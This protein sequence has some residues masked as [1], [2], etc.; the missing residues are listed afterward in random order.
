MHILDQGLKSKISNLTKKWF[1]KGWFAHIFLLAFTLKSILIALSKRYKFWFDRKSKFPRQKSE[2][3]QTI[4]KQNDASYIG[5][6]AEWCLLDN[7]HFD[8]WTPFCEEIF[9]EIK[10]LCEPVR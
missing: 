5:P 1:S 7:V 4:E 9:P 3:S 8:D 10:I 2:K 6:P